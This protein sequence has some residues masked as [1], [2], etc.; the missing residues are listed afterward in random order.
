M[1]LNVQKPFVWC[2]VVFISLY[3][4]AET[5]L[6]QHNRGTSS[7]NIRTLARSRYHPNVQQQQQQ[8]SAE[9][10]VR[11]RPIVVKCHPNSM[12]VVVQADM[13][14]TGLQVDGH[15][16]RLGPHSVS[17]ESSC[18]AVPSGE[19]EFT[20]RA[21]LLDCGTKLSSNKE[22]IIYST[23]LVYSPVTS[24]GS[25]LRLDGATIPVECH[26][27]NKYAVDSFSLLP[28]WI[29]LV[30]TTS[31]QNQVDFNFRLMTDNW[32]FQRGAHLYFLGDLI[33]FEVSAII[34]NHLPLRVFIDHCVATPAADAEG[35]L[36]YDFI[37]H[38][39]CLTDAYLTSSSSRFLPRVKEHKLR[40][41]MDAFRFS[42]EARSQVYITCHIKAVP[43]TSTI[44][45]HNRACSLIEKRWQSVDGNDQACTSCDIS[46]PFEEP[47]PIEP[48][49]S[50]IGTKAWSMKTSQE[51][52]MQKMPEPA[53]NVHFHPGE[54]HS[55]H[56]NL[57][58]SSSRFTKR[59]TDTNLEKTM[60]LGP[61][62]VL[63][64]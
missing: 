64:S 27:E 11:P 59:A 12:E 2:I 13:F 25:L 56:G 15:H 28:K 46:Q 49:T 8:Q 50:P 40:F 32:Q 51:S 34:G 57:H 4:F 23:V 53:N 35:T 6:L 42:Q 24:S 60:Q 38:H 31:A 10:S 22:K 37:E 17:E 41:Q 26:Y 54:H 61:L 43:I 44:D 62:I 5:R 16:L 58:Q 14:D 1:D 19:A 21:H 55:Q 63:P 52:L 39:G 48:P 36:R 9:L 18:R 47:S 33:H 20:M 45:S 30:S 29:P 3:T 7:A